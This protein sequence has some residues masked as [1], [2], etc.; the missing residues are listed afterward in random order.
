MERVAQGRGDQPA[1]PLRHRVSD[2]L[3][4]TYVRS[5]TTLKYSG[6]TA[7]GPTDPKRDDAT[8]FTFAGS[9]AV[10]YR[11]KQ[12]QAAV[13]NRG[14][15]TWTFLLPD[16]D[17][18]DDAYQP[19]ADLLKKVKECRRGQAVRLTYDPGECLFWLRDI[20]PVKPPEEKKDPAASASP[21]PRA[22]AN[23]PATSSGRALVATS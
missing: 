22:R 5:G 17:P 2:E 13:V 19:D 15:L 18:K 4:L 16:A 7:A 10:P 23:S 9:R 21:T 6:A 3:S 20:E 12:V 11:G 14:P 8:V 1:D